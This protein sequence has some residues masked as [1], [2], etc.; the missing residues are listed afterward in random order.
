MDTSGSNDIA[1]TID[2]D[3]AM[4][5]VEKVEANMETGMKEKEKEKDNKMK[6]D[7]SPPDEEELTDSELE[8]YPDSIMAERGDMEFLTTLKNQLM[9]LDPLDR[10]EF[11]ATLEQ[12]APINPYNNEFTSL[13]KK[14]LL[15]A[16][17]Y[18]KRT[19]FLS[20]AE[21]ELQDIDMSPDEKGINGDLAALK[22]Y[23][24]SSGATLKHAKHI[25]QKKPATEE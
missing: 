14:R 6:E 20:K 23:Q 5:S 24:K 1:P 21:R 7:V 18:R 3:Q 25:K 22:E 16:R 11:L 19:E 12:A 4:D 17:T 8:D 9:M 10:V 15:K 13:S 2:Q